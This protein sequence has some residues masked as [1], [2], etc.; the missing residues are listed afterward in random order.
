MRGPGRRSLSPILLGVMVAAALDVLLFT[1]WLL[2]RRA[3][4]HL[5]G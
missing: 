4:T 2:R 5:R 1:G 3:G